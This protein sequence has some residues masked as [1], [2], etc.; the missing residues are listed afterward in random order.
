MSNL[1]DFELPDL[2]E[3]LTHQLDPTPDTPLTSL[4]W[5]EIG[6]DRLLIPIL[7]GMAIPVASR[8]FP[9]VVIPLSTLGAF[10]IP[11]IVAMAF[12]SGPTN[13]FKWMF[14]LLAYTLGIICGSWD[15]LLKIS[16]GNSLTG[17]LVLFSCFV[18]SL[19]LCLF[20]KKVIRHG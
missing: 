2:D 11:G 8:L 16:I 20:I 17:G 10:A 19:S 9:S 6:F 1:F 15:W 4:D 14:T 5:L 18:L 7:I 3:Q 12:L 13:K